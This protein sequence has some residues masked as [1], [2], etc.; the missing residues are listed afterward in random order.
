M[1]IAMTRGIVWIV[2]TAALGLLAGCGGSATPADLAAQACDAQVKTQLN[3]K[4][5]ALD[6]AAL[7]STKTDDG[8]GGQLL[9]AKITVDAGLA[10]ETVQDLECT[11]RLADDG[12]T[13]EVLNLR[14]I[15]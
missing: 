12:T 7:A 14:F 2:P 11:V 9:T 1:E 6:L 13:A 3:G 4:P 10:D 5:Y 8:R 15:W